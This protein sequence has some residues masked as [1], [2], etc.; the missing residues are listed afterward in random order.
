MAAGRP[1]V[2]ETPDQAPPAR[3]IL[4]GMSGAGKA[5]AAAALEAA[6]LE[7]TDNLSP[8]LIAAWAVRAD[9]RTGVAVV[10]A[11]GGDAVADV[12]PP[13]GVSTLF[14]TASP[15]VLTRRLGESSRPHPCAAA[16]GP[17]AAIA[18]EAELLATLRGAAD[19]VIDTGE[20]TPSELGRR[21]TA[22][23]AGP[24][25]APA[26]QLTVSSFGFRFGPQPEADW[27]L[28]VRFLRNPFWEPALRPLT[29]LDDPVREYVL[30]DPA[31]EDLLA[32]L[33]ELLLWVSDQCIR[34][35]RRHLHVAVGCT[36]GR[37]R[38][39][40]IAAA[41]ARRLGARG[42]AVEV[43]HRDVARPDPR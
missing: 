31:T 13:G 24:E 32:R 37:H 27:V 39:V 22:L 7:V 35:R 33:T 40:V 11:R 30:A 34:H 15:A 19:V 6:G 10:D 3:W 14:L 1:S 41:L 17:A 5:T 21:V 36:G 20:L 4:T 26:L 38:S 42:R 28:D 18:R 12:V 16:G 43:R 23:I 25:P 2:D 29:G 9:Q 8:K